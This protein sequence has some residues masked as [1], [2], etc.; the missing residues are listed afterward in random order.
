[1][2]HATGTPGNTRQQTVIG[3]ATQRSNIVRLAHRGFAFHTYEPHRV[4]GP[5]GRALEFIC[6]ASLRRSKRQRATRSGAPQDMQYALHT[7]KANCHDGKKTFTD[8]FVV[9]HAPR[10]PGYEPRKI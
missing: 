6:L 10:S 9:D 5:M 4:W 8:G 7:M 2:G 3:T 1:M